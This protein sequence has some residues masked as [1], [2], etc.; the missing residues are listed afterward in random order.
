MMKR[1]P[2]AVPFL[3]ICSML[4]RFA[5]VRVSQKIRN[6]GFLP[7]RRTQGRGDIMRFGQPMLRGKNDSEKRSRQLGSAQMQIR[8]EQIERR[9]KLIFRRAEPAGNSDRIAAKKMR[10]GVFRIV[11]NEISRLSRDAIR[12]GGAASIGVFR[13]LWKGSEWLATAFSTDW[14]CR[15]GTGSLASPRRPNVDCDIA[16]PRFAQQRWIYQRGTSG[17][18]NENGYHPLIAI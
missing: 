4:Q 5:D 12:V 2:V 6:F 11:R 18:A 14:N 10:T 15:A 8:R 1:A 9:S 3:F 17:A 7:A 16:C 13:S